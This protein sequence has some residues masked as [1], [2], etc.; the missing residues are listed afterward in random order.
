MITGKNIRLRAIERDDIQRFTR[1]INDAEVIK[2]TSLNFPISNAMEEK[3]FDRQ[4]EN[5]PTQGQILAIETRVGNQ[6][7]HIGTCDF[8]D[9]EP[10]N[11]SAEF[12]IMI[13]DKEYWNKGCGRET[14]KLMLQHGFEDL[15]LNRIYLYVLTENS[16]GIKAYEA[17]G[18]VKEGILRQALYKNGLYNDVVVMS[19]LHSEWKGFE[20]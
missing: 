17:A 16:R 12:G 9:I 1:W 13:G 20:S 8:H 4:L 14:T 5:V 18:F 10:V 2:F 6:W 11:H 3:W 15:N 7:V 19:V